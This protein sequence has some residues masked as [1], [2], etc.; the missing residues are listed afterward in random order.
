MLFLI[1]VVAGRRAPRS[2]FPAENE[3]PDDFSSD[4]PGGSVLASR[5]RST[6]HAFDDLG[7][8]IAGVGE[9]V[10]V[11]L[12]LAATIDD[13]PVPQQSQVVAHRR[14]AHVKLVA[15]PPDMV[16]PLGEQGDDLESGRVA[17][18]LEQDSL[19]AEW[20]LYAARPRCLALRSLRLDGFFILRIAG[21]IGIRLLKRFDRQEAG[22][23][24]PSPRGG[25]RD[26]NG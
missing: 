2:G 23:S 25:H 4:S 5:G 17:D 7:K 18:L 1:F 9:A 10:E 11:V 6:T 12:A 8:P 19:P 24:L 15:Q 21:V 16:L 26:K 22:A 20:S 14:L 13:S 3:P